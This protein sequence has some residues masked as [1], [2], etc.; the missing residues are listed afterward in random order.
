[1]AEGEHGGPIIPPLR[2][3]GS[4]IKDAAGNFG[5]AAKGVG[6]TALRFLHTAGSKLKEWFPVGAAFAFT[7]GWIAAIAGAGAIGLFAAA[8]GWRNHRRRKIADASHES[9]H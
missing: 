9:G 5:E 6:E 2:E 3:T 4:D 7:P 8:R 1:M